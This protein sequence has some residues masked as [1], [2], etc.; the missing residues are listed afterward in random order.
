MK[1]VIAVDFDR[2]KFRAIEIVQG[3]SGIDIVRYTIRDLPADGL[4]ASWIK[5]VWNEEKFARAWIVGS[6]SNAIIQYKS[7]MLPMLPED[8]LAAAAKMELEGSGFGEDFLKIMLYRHRDRDMIAMKMGLIDNRELEAIYRLFSQAGLKIAW[9]GFRNH[10]I[11]NFIEFN[12]QFLKKAQPEVFVDVTPR[13]SELGV[14]M[15]DQLIFCREFEPGSEGLVENESNSE[16][17]DFCQELRLSLEASRTLDNGPT[18]S[19][20]VWGFGSA[21]VLTAISERITAETGL[22]LQIPLKTSL[23]GSETGNHTPELAP[24]IGLG[25]EGIGWSNT[26]RL[27]VFSRTQLNERIRLRLWRT[28]ALYG[29]AA[30]IF[31]AGIIL[32]I[33][34][35]AEK[36]QKVS[37]WLTTH[38]SVLIS[39]RRAESETNRDRDEVKMLQGWISEENRELEFFKAIQENLPEGTLIS[40][41]ILEDGAVKELSGTTPAVSLVLNRLKS[42]PVLNRLQL[43]GSIEVTPKGETFHLQGPV[44]TSSALIGLPPKEKSE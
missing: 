3:K 39:L 15:G 18:S 30:M 20:S 6:I 10:G 43:K 7:V 22:T 36:A 29:I 31:T 8:Q 9:F 35:R 33:H 24:L 27:H 14:C 21:E 16:L 5:S 4:S 42:S 28:A 34:A 41:V 2:I 13:M 11:Q 12:H 17:R 38:S 25:L 40:D 32:G 19:D 1:T 26:E 44:G 23:T 37:A